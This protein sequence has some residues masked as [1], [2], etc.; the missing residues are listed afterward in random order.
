MGPD[1][2][3]KLNVDYAGLKLETMCG[4]HVTPPIMLGPLYHYHKASLCLENN[5]FENNYE[6]N[7]R[8]VIKTRENS[9]TGDNVETSELIKDGDV[10]NESD[11]EPSMIPHSG[12]QAYGNDGFGIYG[13]YDFNGEVPVLDEC[14]GHFGAVGEDIEGP[15]VYHYHY[16]NFTW[17]G[18]ETNFE[19]YWIGCQGPSKGLCK[20]TIPANLTQTPSAS[21]ICGNGC[22][23]QIC[24]QPGTSQQQLI[25]YLGYW[26]DP[27]WL[28]QFTVNPYMA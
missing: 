10:E 27:N 6:L 2:A 9:R 4:G 16:K 8:T 7:E 26:G 11:D 5:N 1:E 21:P 15:V 20:D 3:E 25:D 28:Q 12:L 23:Y 13:L 22:G 19:P 24:V 14:N 17:D 18:N